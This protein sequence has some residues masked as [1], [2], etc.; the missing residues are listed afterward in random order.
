MSHDNPHQPESRDQVAGDKTRDTVPVRP[1]RNLDDA[2]DTETDAT[3]ENTDISNRNTRQR[4]STSEQPEE[5]EKLIAF[6]QQNN[7]SLPLPIP[8]VE[9]MSELKKETPELYSVYVHA[10]NSS[11]EA[12]YIERTAPYTGP[13]DNAASG[14]KYGLT[15]VLAVLVVS[16]I[17]LY[18]DHPW[19]AA[20]LTGLDLV[21]L[22]AVFGST[23]DNSDN[24]QS[25]D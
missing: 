4:S 22:A 3:P 24:R 2:S 7:I 8:D 15:V 16:T 17:A 20:F 19:F 6:L 14:R 21:G 23:G 11:I 18:L 13:I 25:S 1:Q 5:P 12:D 10:L 9:K